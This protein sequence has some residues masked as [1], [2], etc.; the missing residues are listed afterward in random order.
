MTEN[1]KKWE[2]ISAGNEKLGSPEAALDWLDEALKKFE[3]F[4]GLYPVEDIARVTKLLYI[5]FGLIRDLEGLSFDAWRA[6]MQLQEQKLRVSKL[7]SE[8]DELEKRLSKEIE[9]HNI[10]RDSL[11]D[12]EAAVNRLTGYIDG[13]E[14]GK[15]PLMVP[16]NRPRRLDEPVPGNAY[17]PSDAYLNRHSGYGGS[18]TRKRWYHK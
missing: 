8:R 16:D 6:N 4:P 5:D 14:D 17:S 3:T 10:T 1:V 11:H 2:R 9:D 15:P 18:Q 13:L 7:T 12:S